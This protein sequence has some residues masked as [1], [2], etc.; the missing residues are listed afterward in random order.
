MSVI[1]NLTNWAPKTDLSPPTKSL[2]LPMQLDSG[3]SPGLLLSLMTLGSVFVA[4]AIAWGAITKV[5]EL[6]VA[7]GQLRP[8]GSVH[9][10]QHLEGGIVE[11]ILVSEGQIVEKGMPLVRLQPAQANAD[12]D[13][14]D[15]RRAGLNLRIERLTA[16]IENR[17]IAFGNLEENFPTVAKDERS[18]YEAARAQDLSERQALQSQ[19]DQHNSEAEGLR[20]QASSLKRQLALQNEQLAIRKDLVEEGYVSKSQYIEIQRDTE[21]VNEQ[22]QVTQGQL[23]SAVEALNEAQIKLGEYDS[24]FKS[25]LADDR[26][27]ATAE[28]GE[29]DAVIPK[30]E[31]RVERLT[32]RA[33]I[34]GIIQELVPKSVGQVMRPGDLIASIVPLDEEIVAEIQIPPQDIAHIKPGEK[35][36]I[37]VSTFDSVRY[38]K[39]SGTVQQISATTFQTHDGVPYYK[40]IVTL[41]RDYVTY[42][43]QKQHVVPGMV[44]QAE[45][46]TGS[47]SLLAYMLKPIYNN[48]SAAFSER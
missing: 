27:K 37:Q 47:K 21:K 25:Q 6:T 5:N 22:L 15:A 16:L 24:K 28:L 23:S 32:V 40:A 35:A 12:L 39:I 43:G 26:A 19:L 44:V 38:G 18:A 13:Q 20:S 4:T 1:A 2:M 33:P 11:E 42:L 7:P 3:R 29:V 34:R 17:P 9:S 36:D 48:Y 10:V 45:I 31:D 41:D 14:L 30:Q 46:A 8:V